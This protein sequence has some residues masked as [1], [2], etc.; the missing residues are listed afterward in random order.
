MTEKIKVL[1]I[2]D[3]GDN[4][5]LLKKFSK[6]LDIHIITFPRAGGD[7]LTTS[8]DKIDLFDSLKISKQVKKIAS[9]RINEI[10]IE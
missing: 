9:L 5:Y 3:S 7:I 6:K 8:H 10:N 1:A 4:L 2:G